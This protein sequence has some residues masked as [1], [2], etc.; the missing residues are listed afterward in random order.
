LETTIQKFKSSRDFSGIYGVSAVELYIDNS[1]MLKNIGAVFHWIVQNHLR[2]HFSE[3]SYGYY[4]TNKK[5]PFIIHN[6]RIPKII[7]RM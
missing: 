6:K 2:R 1:A 4:R 5:Y 3:F 7:I